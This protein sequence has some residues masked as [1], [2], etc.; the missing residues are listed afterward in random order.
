MHF[1]FSSLLAAGLA[2]LPS[3]A[4]S[5]PLVPHYFRAVDV[6]RTVT[7][8]QVQSDLG[9]VLSKG[10]LIFGPSS[11]AFAKATERWNTRS[12]PADIRVVIEVAQES[13]VAKVVKYCY[14]NGIDFLA[15]TRGHGSTSTISKF[16]GI[17][18]NLSKLTGITIQPDKKSALFQGGVYADVVIKKLGNQG[19][20]VPTGSNG[21]VGLLGPAL[22]GGLGR[23]Q[24]QYGLI[25]DNFI[26]LNVVLAN[27]TTTTV[28]ATSNSDLFWAMKGAGHNFGIVTSAYIK[29]YPRRVNTWHYHNYVW[30]QDQL[31]NVFLELNK[32]QG[33]GQIPAQMGA[34]I[35]WSFAYDGP[36]ADAENLLAPFNAIP[37]LSSTKGE[38][39]YSDLLVAQQTD[40]NSASC[41]S[42]PYVG[43]TAWLQT[44]NVT[45]QREIYN[46]F[47]KQI[48]LHPS[49][50]PSA[51]SFFEGYSTR[52]TQA[53]DP[54]SSSYPHRDEYLLV[55]FAVAA[56]P[57][58]VHAARSWA[59]QSLAIWRA[60]QPDRRPATYVNYA[61][62]NEPLETI[63]GYDGQLPRLRALKSKYDPLNKFRWYNPIVTH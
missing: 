47:N 36:A 1:R 8:Q 16:R 4:S 30:S 35:I 29:I 58:L 5:S 19:Y 10:T 56:P 3:I 34:V 20:I 40:I 21:C 51:R 61:V 39:S 6:S 2:L 23:Y 12:M 50:A 18:I 27:G 62:G 38:V 9:K 43:S 17:E 60:G 26:S 37:A 49:F 31:E 52:A 44:Y 15:Y 28:S 22:G 13:D 57:P 7:Q 48:A 14:Q 33:K 41:A 24:G 32:F 42:E 63:Y 55:F 53:I 46:L 59:D 45:S 25:S 54:N 11:Y